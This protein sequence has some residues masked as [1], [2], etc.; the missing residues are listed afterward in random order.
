MLLLKLL[1]L[2]PA[3]CCHCAAMAFLLAHAK[4]QLAGGHA[5]ALQGTTPVRSAGRESAGTGT[6]GM[7]SLA[8]AAGVLGFAGGCARRRQEPGHGRERR[9]ALAVPPSSSAAPSPERLCIVVGNKSY[10][11]WSLRAWLALRVAAGPAGFTEHLVTLAGAGSDAQKQNLLKYSPTGKV[12]A[13]F[14]AESGLSLWESLAICEYVAELF[15]AAR[16]WPEHTAARAL[17]RAASCEMHS[18]FAKM[19]QALP[20]N[21]RRSVQDFAGLNELG[22]AEDIA[23]ICE[24]WQACFDFR[25]PGREAGPFL[26]GRFTVADAMFAPVV[27]RF[28]SYHPALPEHAERYCS[29][30]AAM[31][32]LEE[33]V[34][35]ALL[36]EAR[37]RQYED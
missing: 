14:D 13:L 5:G 30:I 15:P 33:W 12:P 23:R 9:T 6:F 37:I 8:L 1:L 34:Q 27:L 32:E 20:M 19:R 17:A 21:V 16:L 11:S 24:L 28:A 3:A 18:G 4:L 26:F 10:S 2:F 35:A 25:F 22:V 36:E 7:L 31:P 29:A